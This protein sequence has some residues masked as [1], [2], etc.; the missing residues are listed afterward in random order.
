MPG[1]RSNTGAQPTPLEETEPTGPAVTP[2]PDTAPEP[3]TAPLEED[4]PEPDGSYEDPT[5]L[6][7]REQVEEALQEA[8]RKAGR[9]N[10]LNLFGWTGLPRS[11]AAAEEGDYPLTVHEAIAEVT[12][13]V[14]HIA[15][16]RRTEGG[17]RYNF[18]G[19]DDVLAALHP[20]LGDVGLVILPGRMVEHR[21][22]TR[23]TRNGGTLNVALVRVR[24]TLIGPDGT[25]TFGE[26]WGEAGDAGDKAT[27]KALS[28]AYKT[29]ALQ[30][31]SIPTEESRRD[32]PDVTNEPGRP[33]T[34]EEVNRAS[35]AWAAAQRASTL[36][37][38]VGVR[39]RA[40]HLLPVPVPLPEQNG[41]AALGL[42][43]DRRRNELETATPGGEG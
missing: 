8:L 25:K 32:D 31:F 6:S 24:Y 16:D 15:K 21:R 26:A 42:L 13:Q 3:G 14:G 27:Q 39:R 43:F 36:E 23:A 35:N 19:I 7:V 9:G 2:P 29:F 28:Q 41:S 10:P 22:E 40:E 37:E 1:R 12:R 18:R 4:P 20:V 11:T 34:G 5:P 33:F 38:L 30:T 17:E